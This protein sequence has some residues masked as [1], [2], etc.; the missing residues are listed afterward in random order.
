MSSQR[1]IRR[2]IDYSSLQKD[3]G[4]PG[5]GQVARMRD[6]DRILSKK[7]RRRSGHRSGGGRRRSAMSVR[8]RVMLAW[9]A[10]FGLVALLMIGIMASS[11]LGTRK[12]IRVEAGKTGKTKT[13]ESIEQAARVTPLTE[14]QAILLVKRVLGVRDPAMVDSVLVHHEA[15][16]QEVVEFMRT[17]NERDG[18][19]LRISWA[20]NMDRDGQQM[21][22]LY[23]QFEGRGNPTLRLAI[24]TPEESGD[25]KMDFEAFARFCQPSWASIMSGDFETA[26]VR[27][28]ISKYD[29]YNGPFRDDDRWV[30]FAISSTDADEE[31]PEGSGILCGYC[32]ADSP[33][34]KAM[35]RIF[36]GGSLASENVIKSRATLEI[37]P[38]KDAEPRQF[39]I[40]RVL[41]AEWVVPPVPL[42]EQ[43]IVP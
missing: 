22:G 7:R 12:E 43:M 19:I 29:Y 33:Q 15:T 26:R 42:D 34:A 41:S 17:L 40:T 38:V 20:G 2:D 30:C 10:L 28:T 3:K 35:Q 36:S 25:W 11:W 8:N 9:S 18:R 37:R 13:I 27:V 5:I 23:V 1:N 31:K 21:E 6:V 32:Q 39:E 4:P 16:T 14:D 24:L